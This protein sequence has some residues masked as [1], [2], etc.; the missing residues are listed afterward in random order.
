MIDKL[1]KRLLYREEIKDKLMDAIISGMIK[2]GD[3]I[4]ET[5]WAKD[6]GVSQS[7][8]R[9]ALREL[10]MIGVVETI[11][12]K[13]CIVC[14][15]SSEELIDGLK[16]RASLEVHAVE[17]IFEKMDFTFIEKMEEMME[18]MR[19]AVKEDDMRSF[20]K[21]DTE[22]HLVMIEG[23]ENKQLLRLWK[24]CSTHDFTHI[25]AILTDR[26]MEE[27]CER[28]QIILDELKSNNLKNKKQRTIEAIQ[29]HF[30]TLIKEVENKK[31]K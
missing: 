10:E 31:N 9:E 20:S 15:I 17:E 27:L 30:A 11:P 24:Q 18:G 19:A 23:A 22:F 8:I 3:R 1:E 16:V 2:P 6:L 14:E 4:V 26:P 12:Y 28:H 25:T 5:R 13:G 7:P 29:H 21:L